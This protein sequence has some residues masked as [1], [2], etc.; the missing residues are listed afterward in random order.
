MT[1]VSTPQIVTVDKMNGG[2]IIKFADGNCA[3]YSCALLY[4]MLP[5]CEQLNE[6]ALAW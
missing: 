5:R 1:N 4:A 3:F 6:E 2:V